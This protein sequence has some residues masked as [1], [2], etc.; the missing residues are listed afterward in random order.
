VA[1]GT[2]C[3]LDDEDDDDARDGLALLAGAFCE[4]FDFCPAPPGAW[5]SAVMVSDTAV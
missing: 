1:G 5:P 3:W 4:A 2:I